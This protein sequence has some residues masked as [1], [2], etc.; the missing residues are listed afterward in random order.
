VASLEEYLAEM[1]GPGST[2]RAASR[3][4]RA[5]AVISV[6]DDLS[7]VR[8]PHVAMALWDSDR[9]PRSS[10]CWIAWTWALSM[11]WT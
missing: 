4:D 8:E 11:T 6:A 2:L 1:T 7:I 10:T 5:V 3:V 9:R